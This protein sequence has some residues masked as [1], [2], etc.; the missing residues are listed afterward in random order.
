MSAMGDQRPFVS[1][2]AAVSID[3]KIATAE[4]QKLRFG[5]RQDRALMEEL[6]TRADGVL[7]GRGTLETD[8]PP[9]LIRDPALQER[10]RCEKG[11]PHPINIAVCSELLAGL[12]EADFCRCVDTTKYLFTT[13]KAPPDRVAAAQ[14]FARVFVAGVDASGRVDLGDVMRRLSALGVHRLLLEGGGELNFSML[15]RGFVD[16]IY[17]TVCPFV[18]GGRDAPTLF[19][20]CGFHKDS[21]RKLQLLGARPGEYGEVFMHYAVDPT[22]P[23]VGPSA[24]FRKGFEFTEAPHRS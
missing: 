24:V 16:E 14:A 12:D 6:R 19:G 2:N 15:E 7:I 21:V 4:R 11:Q 10:R 13:P 18:F 22:L 9:L 5:S 17:L 8:D 23:T 3:G 1:L 20:G